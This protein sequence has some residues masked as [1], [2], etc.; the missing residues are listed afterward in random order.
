MASIGA[1]MVQRA[2]VLE[3]LPA[4]LREHGINP[5]DVFTG[6]NVDHESLTSDTKLPFRSVVALL[7]RAT[8]ATRRADLGFILG[9]RFTL[10]HHGLIGRLMRCAPT[11]H[12]ALSDFVGW[13]PGYSS[14]A[15]V[16]LSRS[17][18]EV[19]FGYGTLDKISPGL[20]QLYNTV[21]VIGLTMVRELT[22]GRVEP[23]EV[24]LSRR[25]P[26]DTAAFV[27]L[28]HRKLRFDQHRTCIILEHA[29]LSTPLPHADQIERRHVQDELNRVMRGAF[30]QTSVRV[31]HALRPLLH[32]ADI[33]MIN[34]A[35]KLRIHPR[36][37]RR[38]LA[39]EKVTFEA[40]RD[41]VRFA[42]AC[43]LLEM[44]ALPIG[45]VGAAV[46]LASP[47]V[48]ADTFRR[49]SGMSPSEWRKA[50]E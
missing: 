28:V 6:T 18:D 8:S 2:G 46:A 10:T 15:V 49:W 13:Q 25:S 3:A 36:T 43:E 45:E 19:A 27:R 21:L 40:L 1:Q 41:Q 26:A 37:L 44:T 16:Y 17:G 39:E 47:S 29:S 48:F 34:V 30:S 14:G 5:A 38:R 35:D 20:E 4:L 50:R 22:G 12:D 9:S 11:L 32:S 23:V 7:E 31:R 42:V 24:H 33:S